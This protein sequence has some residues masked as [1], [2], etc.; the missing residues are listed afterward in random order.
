MLEGE[1]GLLLGTQIFAEPEDIY[2]H[3]TVFSVVFSIPVGVATATDRRNANSHS[4]TLHPTPVPTAHEK[5]RT[6]WVSFRTDRREAG[7]RRLVARSVVPRAGTVGHA[8]YNYGD[9]LAESVTLLLQDR[10]AGKGERHTP[11]T[12]QNVAL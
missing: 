9:R 12:V 1:W 11:T 5:E 8:F 4:T 7:A 3:S 6:V 2:D 10:Q